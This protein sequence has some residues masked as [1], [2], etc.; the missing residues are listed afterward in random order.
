MLFSSPRTSFNHAL[1]PKRAVGFGRVPLATVKKIK[2][3]FGVTVN[4]VVLAACARAL[5]EYLRAHGETPRRPIV[6]TVPVSE[7]AG[8]SAPMRGNRVS[9]MFIG[10]PVHLDDLALVVHS[11]H[12][13]SIGAKKVYAAFGPSMLA[14]WA[15]LMPPR[16]FAAAMARYSRWRL[17]EYVPP[18]HSV[19][20]SNVPGPPMPLFAGDA[21]LVAAYPL[22][23]VLEGAAVNISVMSYLDAVDIGLITCA[24]A[25]PR[26]SEIARGFER[27]VEELAAAAK[28]QATTNGD[29]ARLSAT[30]R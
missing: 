24:R 21:R 25:V 29:H 19:V 23:P 15:D 14:A 4:D 12:E 5:G 27:A 20:I 22:G 11:I 16:L 30:A 18:A 1:T 7:H 2:N 10:L 9:A 8:E 3:A 26:P 13:Q 6:A 28:T 17:A